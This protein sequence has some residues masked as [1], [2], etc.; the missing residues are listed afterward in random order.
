M[1]WVNVLLA[2]HVNTPMPETQ[3][4]TPSISFPISTVLTSAVI[5]FVLVQTATHFQYIP[6]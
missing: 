2:V 3:L 6:R 1:V 4:I 5:F